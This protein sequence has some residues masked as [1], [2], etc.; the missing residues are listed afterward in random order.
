MRKGIIKDDAFLPFEHD[1]RSSVLRMNYTTL[2]FCVNF[3]KNL[4]KDKHQLGAL[5]KF[6]QDDVDKVNQW[7]QSEKSNVKNEETGEMRVNGSCAHIK[8]S[9]M[10]GDDYVN[11]DKDYYTDSCISTPMHADLEFSEPLEKNLV[12]I[13]MRKYNNELIKLCKKAYMDNDRDQ[14]GDW[15]DENKKPMA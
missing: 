11:K 13:R 4:D 12:R 7:A 9:P 5:L 8:Y 14:L 15:I 2:D 6:C 10:D 1:T 3:G